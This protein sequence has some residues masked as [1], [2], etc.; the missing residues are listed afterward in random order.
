MTSS[1]SNWPQEG[2]IDVVENA[3]NAQNNQMSLHVSS[4]QGQCQID[5]N[6]DMT[7]SKDR[8]GDCNEEDTE[9]CD[10]N[11][12]RTNSFGSGFNDNSGGVYAME[13]AVDHVK[14]WFFPRDSIPDD[15]GGPLGDSPDPTTW[16]SPTT[17]FDSQDGTGCDMS[18]HIKNQRIVID[19]T[20]CGAWA[21]GTWD[22][23]GCASS[24][25]Y[26]SCEDYV[27]NKPGDFVSAFWTFNSMR[28]FT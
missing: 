14:I 13:W 24:T 17:A 10:A 8:W 1:T 20:F 25:G 2:E 12:P 5:Q 15:S 19:T 3:N 23:S 22:S 11:D 16:G 7:A 18:A 26:G 6:A 27:Q 9:G 4:A 21:S 28:V